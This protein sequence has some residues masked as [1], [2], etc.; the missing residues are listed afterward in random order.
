MVDFATLTGAIA[1]ALGREYAGLYANDDDLA[2]KIIQAGKTV[3]ENLA[4][5]A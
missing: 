5:A 3:G 4:H 1:V 2:D